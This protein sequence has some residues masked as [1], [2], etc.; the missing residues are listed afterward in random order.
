MYVLHV[1]FPF[2]IEEDTLVCVLRTLMKENG[3]P[4]QS[5]IIAQE[6]CL[7]GYVDVWPF[8]YQLYV[9]YTVSFKYQEETRG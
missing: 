6:L 5:E 7:Y 4:L 9:L 1:V 8:V 3:N 2:V